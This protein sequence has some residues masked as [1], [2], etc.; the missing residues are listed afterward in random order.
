M[1]L[2]ANLS[3]PF[4]GAAPND[5]S[6]TTLR[7]AFNEVNTDL[8]L[9][10]AAV[11]HLNTLGITSGPQG[12]TGPSGPSGP[13][14]AI[15]PQ[16]PIGP[17]GASSTV[18]GPQGPQGPIGPSGPPGGP[19]GPQGDIGPSGPSGP[20]GPT[21]PASN[22]PGPI[23]PL[24][25]AGPTGPSGPTGPA[26]GPQ[27]PTGPAGSAGPAGPS[28]STG[29]A[30]PSG[31][32]GTDGA[33]GP[34]GP[35]GPA[36]S[37]G[38]A[39]PAGPSGSPGP[40]GPAG[41]TGPSGPSGPSGAA[42][43]VPGPTGPSGPAG[44]TGPAGPA[45]PSG[46]PGPSGPAGSTGPAGPAGP[47]GPIGPI[48]PAG[49]TGPSGPSGSPG[50]QGPA[51]NTG[52]SGPSGPSGATGAQGPQGPTGPSGAQGPQGPI[53]PIG[54]QGLLGPTG[55]SGVQGPQG[56]LGA[57]GPQG[58]Q[59]AKAGLKY[60]WDGANSG[61]A[62]TSGNGSLRTSQSNTYLAWTNATNLYISAYDANGVS[63]VNYITQW[64]AST[65]L[66]KGQIIM[67][68]SANDF[69]V[70]NI[71]GSVINNSTYFTIPVTSVG[72]SSTVPANNTTLYLEFVRTGDVG[73]S[74]PQGPQGTTTY[75]YNVKSPVY[76]AKGDGSTDDTASIQSAITAAT[77]TGGTV[78][79][80]AGT[81]KIT[82]GVSLSI[83]NG[84][85][86]GPRVHFLGE[87]IGA[88]IIKQ[89]S[90]SSNG[91][92]IV[93]TNVNCYVQI[94]SLTILGAGGGSGINFSGGWF[95]RIRDCEI[96]NWINGV[97][98]TNMVAST[99]DACY[100][101]YNTTGV[102]I[103]N[104]AGTGQIDPSGINI[105][106]TEI[107]WNTSI[108]ISITGP[109]NF[110]MTSCYVDNNGTI[111]SST[112]AVQLYD[113]GGVVAEVDPA[114]FVIQ[115]TLFYQNGGIAD[116]LVRQDVARSGVTGTIIGCGFTRTPTNYT[117]NN[118][119]LQG[120]ASTTTFPVSI[121]SCGF[122]A[123]NYSASRPTIG[124]S[125]NWWPVLLQACNFGSSVD[126]YVPPTPSN[127][128]S[129]GVLGQTIVDKT[130]GNL[131]FCYAPNTWAKIS[132]LV[133]ASF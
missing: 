33:A 101:K 38:P 6:G 53:G 128:T 92:N 77:T 107:G 111:G 11:D 84:S 89:F 32:A 103:T 49:G 50:P 29:P 18:P 90:S 126:Q 87:G 44:S 93:S 81:Y 2:L 114:G 98:A 58:P 52:P 73:P 61:V 20:Q 34:T 79:F 21:G 97:Y 123:G 12:P 4:T 37:T 119:S 56:P 35:A 95:C 110:T 100:I 78:F 23:G 7:D 88:S 3:L 1:S 68:D 31:P 43:T 91:I 67:Q 130:G 8:S 42:S 54:T 115:G 63:L 108:G 122:Y 76:G 62:G 17:I 80:P 133:Y 99:I 59:G 72:S 60:Y 14:G 117:T 36:G 27:G 16:G 22:I 131:Y 109:S 30:G 48:G 75:V 13:S 121:I 51:G 112:Y 102:A 24:G 120:S 55:P 94:S 28:G 132:G 96:Y 71:T 125:S 116:I 40:S 82:S 124:N 118:I 129:P 57:Q 19:Q 9:I 105:I 41:S 26:G 66:I 65:G 45:G 86:P 15:G 83:T 25:P 64:G 47:A 39:G 127:G 85:D 10:A 69:V 5:G 70:Y 74:G 106:N 46:S 104:A 113:S